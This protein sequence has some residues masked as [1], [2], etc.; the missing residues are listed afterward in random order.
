MKAIAKEK[1]KEAKEKEAEATA[2]LVDSLVYNRRFIIRADYLSNNRGSRI[3]VQQNINF[4]MV[5]SAEAVIQVGN[6]VGLGYN[7][8]GGITT[9]G[10]ITTYALTV[11]KKQTLYYLHYLQ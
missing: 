11:S 9:E 1:K 5:D 10:R 4:I 7:G 3:P 8:V 6:N 2:A